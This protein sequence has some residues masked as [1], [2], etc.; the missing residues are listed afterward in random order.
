L[1]THSTCICSKI[2]CEF[3][4]ALAVS[5]ERVVGVCECGRANREARTSGRTGGRNA[6]AKLIRS[7]DSRA[8]QDA[9]GPPIGFDNRKSFMGWLSWNRTR[10][11]RQDLFGGVILDADQE[12]MGKVTCHIPMGR[13]KHPFA[14]R[15]RPSAVYSWALAS[16]SAMLNACRTGKG[17]ILKTV[18]L[19]FE[20]AYFVFEIVGSNHDAN[21]LAGVGELAQHHNQRRLADRP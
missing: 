17:M 6:S 21:A 3:V 20:T 13:S 2:Q 18:V 19:M 1:I 4:L 8:T 9:W 12:L 11:E 16:P 7:R 14:S 5:F 15:R 10:G